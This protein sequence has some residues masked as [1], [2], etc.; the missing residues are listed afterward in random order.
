[1]A[2]KKIATLQ[3]RLTEALSAKNMTQTDL[4]RAIGVTRS[5]INKYLKN[6]AVPP[7]E[8][9]YLMSNALGVSEIWLLGYDVSM[10]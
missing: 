2:V 1:M 3:E 10:D 8:R 5:C 4:G 6:R 7:L 9:V